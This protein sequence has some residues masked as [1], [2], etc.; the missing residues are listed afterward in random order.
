MGAEPEKEEAPPPEDIKKEKKERKEKKEKDE[1]K[2][3]KKEKKEKKAKEEAPP[4]FQAVT[5]CLCMGEVV[6]FRPI[7]KKDKVQVC[8]MNVGKNCIIDVVSN[9]PDIEKGG[10]Y[11]VAVATVFTKNNPPLEVVP[12]KTGG[13]FSQ[14][15]FCGPEELGWPSDVLDPNKPVRWDKAEAG[16]PIPTYEEVVQPKKEAPA[17]AGGGKDKKKKK[18]G[19]K[20]GD[21]D[22]DLDALLNEFKDPNAPPV[23]EASSAGKKKKK[24]KDGKDDED[25]DAILNEFKDDSA[26]A[27]STEAPPT[28]EEK[29]AVIEAAKEEKDELLDAKALAN[30]KKKEKKKA[31]QSAA[32][33][34]EGMWGPSPGEDGE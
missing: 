21:E 3:E 16:A 32:V 31:K 29:A 14:G 1:D 15:M 18:G 22:E 11:A 17:A 33:G 27:P 34:G 28:E 24:G 4:P 7:P 9:V 12:R 25:L 8:E 30:R 23:E 10:K 2:K 26:P 20:K 5:D 6:G 19:A 13:V